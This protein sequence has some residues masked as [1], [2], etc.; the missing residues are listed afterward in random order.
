MMQRYN[1]LSS[2]SLTLRTRPEVTR[3]FDGLELIP[4]GVVALPEWGSPGA[5]QMDA[6]SGLAGY[7]GIGFKS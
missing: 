2:V 6:V 3:F 4:P 7:C 1:A 5:A